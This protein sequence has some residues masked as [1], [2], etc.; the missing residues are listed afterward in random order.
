MY[1]NLKMSYFDVKKKKTQNVGMSK[2]RVATYL[3][4][5]QGRLLPDSKKAYW[6]TEHIKSLSYLYYAFVI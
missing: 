2:T 4:G 3:E 5:P 6:V 1:N